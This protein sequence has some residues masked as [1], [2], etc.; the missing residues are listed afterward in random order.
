[1]SPKKR[2]DLAANGGKEIDSPANGD[3]ASVKYGDAGRSGADSDLCRLYDLGY[4]LAT[5][6]D[7]RRYIA[8]L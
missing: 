7:L 6:R 5:L 8:G 4:R 1:M 2:I 3:G